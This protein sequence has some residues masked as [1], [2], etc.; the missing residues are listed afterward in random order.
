MLGTGRSSLKGSALTELTFQPGHPDRNR[1]RHKQLVAGDARREEHRARQEGLEMGC[2]RVGVGWGMGG[3]EVLCV[4]LP[5][6]ATMSSV[7]TGEEHFKERVEQVG[8][9]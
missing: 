8:G 1:K 9:P 2:G 5:D 6:D 7:I 4:Y 3:Q